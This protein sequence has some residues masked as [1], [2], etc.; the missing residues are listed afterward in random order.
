MEIIET[1]GFPVRAIASHSRPY[2][3]A[4]RLALQPQAHVVTEELDRRTLGQGI[5]LSVGVREKR[6][7]SEFFLSAAGGFP[8]VIH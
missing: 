6:P 3:V 5:S 8:L 2:R 7:Y 1:T 4:E